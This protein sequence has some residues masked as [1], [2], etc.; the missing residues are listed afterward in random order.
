M[1]FPLQVPRSQILLTMNRSV[2]ALASA[3]RGTVG[4]CLWDLF[5]HN[6]A[7]HLNHS[8]DWAWW[9]TQMASMDVMH[10]NPIWIG[11]SACMC[12]CVWGGGACV[13]VGVF[14]GQHTCVSVR[15]RACVRAR[16]SV[17]VW[18]WKES[19]RQMAC[20]TSNNRKPQWNESYRTGRGPFHQ[21]SQ[22]TV[23]LTREKERSDLL[24]TKSL[25]V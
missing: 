16:V 22:V 13:G 20:T 10:T 2:V 18:M 14:A 19:I 25:P 5:T 11:V 6:I 4:V 9:Q 1:H 21:L 23:S 3:D 17:C 8:L 7:T 15:A 12:V 24:C